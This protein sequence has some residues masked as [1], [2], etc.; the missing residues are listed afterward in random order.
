MALT[1]TFLEISLVL[2]RFTPGWR[3]GRMRSATAAS[4]ARAPPFPRVERWGRS[5]EAGRLEWVSTHSQEIT[6]YYLPLRERWPFSSRKHLNDSG[7]VLLPYLALGQLC[8][9][10]RRKFW[11]GNVYLQNHSRTIHLC[12][13]NIMI[14]SNLRAKWAPGMVIKRLS[15][16]YWL[17]GGDQIVERDIRTMDLDKRLTSHTI[18]L[19]LK[20]TRKTIL[21]YHISCSAQAELG[22]R[23]SFPSRF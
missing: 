7:V 2:G 19:F 4:C 11:C 10:T 21:F 14:Q 8:T 6:T 17:W 18:R 9:W 1:G 22:V 16:E 20:Y 23:Q 5:L 15:E 13:H 3:S 12:L